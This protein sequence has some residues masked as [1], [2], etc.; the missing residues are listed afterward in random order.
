M[1]KYLNYNELSERQKQQVKIWYLD[2]YLMNKE[3]RNISYNEIVN[4]GN[5]VKDS[6]KDFKDY[7]DM[8]S[9]VEEDFI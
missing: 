7:V 2:D 6:D 8:I 5:L 4:I 3:S 9:F 1:S